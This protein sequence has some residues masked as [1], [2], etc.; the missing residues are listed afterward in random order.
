[1]LPDGILVVL[2]SNNF[3]EGDGHINCVESIEEFKEQAPM[4]VSYFEGTLN[5]SNYN[6]FMLIGLK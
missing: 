6:R 2:Q 3:K 4:S 5:L 1:M